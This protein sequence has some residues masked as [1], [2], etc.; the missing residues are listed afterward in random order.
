MRLYAAAEKA[1]PYSMHMRLGLCVR[2]GGLWATTVPLL[3][4]HLLS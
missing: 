4:Q 2:S 3:H 1:V